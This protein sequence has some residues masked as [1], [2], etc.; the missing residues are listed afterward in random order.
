MPAST[1]I[2]AKYDTPQVSEQASPF[3]R[4][5]TMPPRRAYPRWL[6]TEPTILILDDSLSSV[7]LWKN[8][9]VLARGIH[10]LIAPRS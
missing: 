6:R 1:R 2:P 8:V 5:K 3:R 4:P 10:A 7:S 9:T